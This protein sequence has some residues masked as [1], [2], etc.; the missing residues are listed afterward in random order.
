MEEVDI[1][2]SGTLTLEQFQVQGAHQSLPKNVYVI[3]DINHFS[4][5]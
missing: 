4:K 3:I 2:G 1:D 5:K